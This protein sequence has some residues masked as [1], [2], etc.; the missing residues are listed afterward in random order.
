MRKSIILSIIALSF[1]SCKE[2]SKKDYSSNFDKEI[3]L[4]H[5][6]ESSKDMILEGSV[7]TLIE[8]T[9]I[10]VTSYRLNND[11]MLFFSTKDFKKLGAY[12][13]KGRGPNEFLDVMSLSYNG[14]KNGFS[15]FDFYNQALVDLKIQNIDDT[16]TIIETDKMLAK[17]E[18]LSHGRLDILKYNEEFYVSTMFNGNGKMFDVLDKN[19]ELVKSFGDSPIKDSLSA[20][21]TLCYL[22]GY[23]ASSHGIFAYSAKNI[24]YIGIYKLNKD[25]MPEKVA[26]DHYFETV[27]EVRGDSFLLSK[28]KSR[29]NVYALFI[30]KKYIYNLFTDGLV[31]EQTYDIPEK[32]TGNIVFIFDHN[33]N[34][35]AKLKLDKN[36]SSLTISEDE[37]TIYGLARDDYFSIVTY[38][39]PDL[40]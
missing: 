14:N 19:L 33:G 34:S 37:K 40:E 3:F 23:T 16:I 15:V 26:E 39:I 11:V 7:I 8:D 21:T 12:G 1:I 20:Y 2:S 36:L 35:I 4:T 18:K 17:K 6:R 5:N 13:T 22:G 38:T 27:Y 25:G 9:I 30:G 32:S 28:D 10:N 24:P 29:G 31:S